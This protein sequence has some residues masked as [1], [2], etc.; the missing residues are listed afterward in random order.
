[1]SISIL[2][3]NMDM[4]RHVNM[5]IFDFF[6]KCIEINLFGTILFQY[7]YGLLEIIDF[8]KIQRIM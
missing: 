2:L 7:I 1:M 8:G 5:C 6:G 3:Y 4:K